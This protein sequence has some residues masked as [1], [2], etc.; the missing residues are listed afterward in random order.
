MSTKSQ[1]ALSEDLPSVWSMTTMWTTLDVYRYICDSG[2]S[3]YAECFR[4][5]AINGIDLA[6]L[7]VY[8]LQRLGVHHMEDAIRMHSM[9]STTARTMLYNFDD[10]HNPPNI[11]YLGAGN[12]YVNSMQCTKI[13]F[14]PLP[15]QDLRLPYRDHGDRY[16][17]YQLP[18]QSFHDHCMSMGRTD[19]WKMYNSQF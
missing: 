2:F 10:A 15:S 11:S 18:A 17:R 14:P 5:N 4:R 13:K 12:R 8:D 6:K 19:A 1:A 7:T 3:K 9:I 16:Y